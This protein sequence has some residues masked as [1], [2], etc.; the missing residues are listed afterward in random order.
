MDEQCRWCADVD[1]V[2]QGARWVSK[3]E[4]QG[5]PPRV[6][7]CDKPWSAGCQ[8]DH[9]SLCFIGDYETQAEAVQAMSDHMHKGVHLQG[10]A[11]DN[12]PTQKCV[13]R[14][15]KECVR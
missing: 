15:G 11:D 14:A 4:H 6:Y 2:P 9:G 7:P 12:E 1:H 13:I 10:C 5:Y 3:H 8:T